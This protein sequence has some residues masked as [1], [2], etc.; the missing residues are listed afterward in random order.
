MSGFELRPSRIEDVPA[1]QAIYAHWVLHGVASFETAPPD[2]NEIIRRR[3]AVL[4]ANLPYVVA[5]G[6]SGDVAGYAYATLYRP[7]A[8][9]RFT[10]EDS[11]YVSP[12]CAGRG[13]GRG[14]LQQVIAETAKAGFRQMIAVIGG[15]LENAGSVRLHEAC[16]FRHTGVLTAVGF[17]FDRWV[18]TALMQRDLCL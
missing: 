8:A 12:E 7:R 18:D 15:G 9:Y 14:L 10:V 17:K 16:G 3:D 13:L 6:D 4:Q 5:V 11:V 2:A 1:I